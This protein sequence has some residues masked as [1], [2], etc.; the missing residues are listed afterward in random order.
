MRRPLVGL[1][2]VVLA[3]ISDGRAMA[4]PMLDSPTLGDVAV[5]GSIRARAYLWDWFGD[6]PEGEYSYPAVLI[7]VGLS[8]AKSSFDW[9]AEV[10]LPILANLP[11]DAVMPAPQ[12]QLGLGATYSAANLNV[13]H[14]VTLFPKQAFVRLKSLG[15]VLGQALN[16]RPHGLQ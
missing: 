2:T 9:Q 15:G 11:V 16:H 8:Q 5:S 7:R 10:A 14:A 12:G 6:A 3:A 4:Q 1:L 13:A